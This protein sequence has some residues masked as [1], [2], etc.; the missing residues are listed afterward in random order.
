MRGTRGPVGLAGSSP[1]RSYRRRSYGRTGGRC[2]YTA[3]RGTSGTA[4]RETAV[5]PPPPAPMT[6]P[7]AAAALRGRPGI[8]AGRRRL[9]LRAG[10][11]GPLRAEPT[12]HSVWPETQ[13][14][15]EAPPSWRYTGAMARGHQRGRRR[16][17]GVQARPPR[18]GRAMPPTQPS[19]S[20]AAPAC[21]H[22]LVGGRRWRRRRRRRRSKAIRISEVDGAPPATVKALLPPPFLAPARRVR[23]LAEVAAHML[24]RRSPGGGA[25]AEAEAT[26]KA[27]VRPPRASRARRVTVVGTQPYGAA[28]RCTGGAAAAAP[29]PAGGGAAPSIMPGANGGWPPWPPRSGRP[30][31]RTRHHAGGD[32]A[33]A[34]AAHRRQT[35]RLRGAEVPARRTGSTQASTRS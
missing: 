9:G 1:R 3:C 14:P 21:R 6:G 8:Q 17:G 19:A 33:A 34:S 27:R 13:T 11:R 28:R 7:R 2:A 23:G 24:R 26:C 20:A 25:A 16:Q 29:A 10:A 18:R 4:S 5:R 35:V 32:V 12:T 31:G 22:A 30:V 15:G